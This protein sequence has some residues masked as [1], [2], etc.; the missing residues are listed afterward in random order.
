M[1]AW[2]E[3]ALACA[4]AARAALRLPSDASPVAVVLGSGLGAFAE[5]LASQTAVPF[6]S[7]PGFPATT[8]PGHRGRLVFGDLGGVPVLA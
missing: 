4:R 2:T 8:V 5:R 7:L 1:P 3:L 6:E